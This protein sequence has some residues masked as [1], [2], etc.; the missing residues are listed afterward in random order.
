M[1]SVVDLALPFTNPS[2]LRAEFVQEITAARN[3]KQ[4]KQ[5]YVPA[6]EGAICNLQL[7]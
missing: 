4:M 2:H 1:L 5:P 7:D 3:A 6:G